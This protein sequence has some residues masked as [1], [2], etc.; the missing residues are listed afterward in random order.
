M[1][2]CAIKCLMNCLCEMALEI[3]DYLLVIVVKLW[4]WKCW[5][6]CHYVV[7]VV[8]LEVIVVCWCHGLGS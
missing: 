7:V 5:V 4:Y 6:L 2:I 1:Q 3:D 8:V